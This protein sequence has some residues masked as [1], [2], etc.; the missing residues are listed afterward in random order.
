MM[1][2]R[3]HCGTRWFSKPG[4]RM[5]AAIEDLRSRTVHLAGIRLGRDAS[6]FYRAEYV[7]EPGP[8]PYSGFKMERTVE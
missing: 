3:L 5:E 7:Y 6:G 4:E 8:M 1:G 2:A